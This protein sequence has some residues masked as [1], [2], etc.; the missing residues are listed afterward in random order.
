MKKERIEY[1]KQQIAKHNKLYYENSEPEITDAEYDELV[2]ELRALIGE[3]EIAIFKLK[4][5]EIDL[6]EGENGFMFE[7]NPLAN[8]KKIR[9]KKPMLSL[10]NVFSRQDLE[11][12]IQ[13]INNFLGL[14][15]GTNHEFTAEP[16]IDGI[17]FSATYKNGI[18]VNAATRGDGEIGEDITE[19]I[20]TI[21]H[22]PH[23]IETDFEEFEVRGEVFMKI[24]DFEALNTKSEKKFSNPRNAAAG[25]LRQLDPL[26]TAQRPLS[27]FTYNA[28][29]YENNLTFL[30]QEE[31]YKM[32]SK[33]GFLVN[34]YKLCKNQE[35]MLEF[36]KQFEEQRFTKSYDAD[37][38][39]YKLNNLE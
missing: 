15:K 9:H 10:S 2:K 14:L 7:A 36:H 29:I 19:N 25:S 24:A 35:E 31:C 3:K 4:E 34:E 20:K 26:I 16:K 5:K 6:F 37:G 18:L 30:T 11:D 23:K 13:K 38:V 17:G 22:F 28:F 8:F 39:V 1:L 21:K 12:F 32:L 27:Y 33:F